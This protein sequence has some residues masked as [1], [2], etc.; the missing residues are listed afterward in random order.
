MSSDDDQ[1]GPLRQKTS[2]ESSG[3]EGSSS[4]N[5]AR[6]DVPEKL[7]VR[8]RRMGVV[9]VSKVDNGARMSPELA[10]VVSLKAF[11]L[12]IITKNRRTDE[13]GNPFV[14]QVGFIRGPRLPESPPRQRRAIGDG[15]RPTSNLRSS[16]FQATP[17]TCLHNVANVMDDLTGDMEDYEFSEVVAPTG[18]C[19]YVQDFARAGYELT[20][21]DAAVIRA[22]VGQGADRRRGVNWAWGYDM[23][24]APA[25]T[26]EWNYFTTRGSTFAAVTR[27][28]YRF[29]EGQKIGMAV[30]R[31]FTITCK[32]AGMGPNSMTLDELE[33]IYGLYNQVNIYTGQIKSVSP[34][35]R[36]FEHDINTFCGCSGAIVFLLDR[37][38]DDNGVI[39]DDYGKAIAV[40][41]GGKHTGPGEIRNIAFKLDDA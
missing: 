24:K 35:G 33:E 6:D 14:G 34:D 23:T 20:G 16:H 12:R 39:P 9:G 29:Q 41:A 4:S 40:H 31:D 32:D 30:Y 22:A 17:T 7:V 36:A 26:N 5:R 11:R 38:Q 28:E 27:D 13:T 25:L 1:R 37:D 19:M 15:A 8:N 10:N 21:G 2:F 18:H 3:S